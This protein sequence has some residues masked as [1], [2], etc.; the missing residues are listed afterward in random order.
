MLPILRRSFSV[1]VNGSINYA[2]AIRAYVRIFYNSR[3]C[4]LEKLYILIIRR[5]KRIASVTIYSKIRFAK[6]SFKKRFN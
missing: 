5:V 1:L 3:F 2:Y 4:N 6:N